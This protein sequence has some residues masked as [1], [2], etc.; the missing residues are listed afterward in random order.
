MIYS[1]QVKNE[2]RGGSGGKLIVFS[3]HG[4]NETNGE[5]WTK[6]MEERGLTTIIPWDMGRITE[7]R[8]G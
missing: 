4:S 3:L 7:K 5:W 2:Q 8:N 1:S 6:Q